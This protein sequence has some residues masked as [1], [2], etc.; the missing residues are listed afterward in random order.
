MP[1]Y[2]RRPLPG[3][4]ADN[5]IGAG[6]KSKPDVIFLRLNGD[7]LENTPVAVGI[8]RKFF[9]E[10]GYGPCFW[11]RWIDWIFPYILLLRQSFFFGPIVQNLL[12]SVLL[13]HNFTANCSTNRR[14]VVVPTISQNVCQP[15]SLQKVSVANITRTIAQTAAIT[16]DKVTKNL[17]NKP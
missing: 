9:L 1:L 13:A 10:Y 2:V 7:Y 16:P 17:N 4:N 11:R 8:L 3:Q 5:N 14:I 12:N 6:F 15:S